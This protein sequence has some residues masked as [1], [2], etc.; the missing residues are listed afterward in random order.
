MAVIPVKLSISLMLGRI[1]VAKRPY[2]IGLY[3]ITALLTI[4][5]L[6]GLIYIVFRCTPVA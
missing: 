4:I 5:A 2:V 1:A 3:I 6:L